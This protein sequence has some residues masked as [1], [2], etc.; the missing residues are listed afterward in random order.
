MDSVDR[1]KQVG[2]SRA[3]PLPG[4]IWVL[5][6]AAFIVALGYGIIAPVLPQF[7]QS[8][9]LGVAA[10]S[11]VVSAF[12][13]FRLMFAPAGGKL[14]DRFGEQPVYVTGLLIVAA[15]TFAVAF[16]QNY[17]QLL[18]FRGL[19]GL[20]STMFSV[21]AMALIVRSAPSHARAR[22]TG[23]YA[24]AFLLG[25]IAG[26]VLGGLMA[27][28]GMSVPFLIYG[29][30]L[31]A[32]AVI[33]QVALSRRTRRKNR[34]AAQAPVLDAQ[35]TAAEQ[36]A[37]GELVIAGLDSRTVASEQEAPTTRTGGS[38][39]STAPMRFREAFAE[40]GYR[41]AL[42]GGLANGWASMGIRVAIYPLFVLH[43]LGVGPAAAGW[44][45][46]IFAIGN[47]AAVTF[48]GRFADRLGRKPFTVTGF[49]VL[50]L[51]TIALGRWQDLGAFLVLSL[52][53]GVGA[54]LLNPAQQAVVADVVGSDRPS[55]K[56]LSRFQMAMD[57]GGIAGPIVAGWIVDHFS[58]GPAFTVSGILALLASLFWLTARE[59]LPSSRV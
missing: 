44:A 23:H 40:S 59:T 38:S 26:P 37:A 56:V 17:W 55:G 29:C 24:S 18:I 5:I 2:K 22:A 20:G 25:S 27:G 54:G 41:A 13:F 32:A 15:S 35:Q 46:T 12:A 11:V 7:A 33:V 6:G 31:V 1:P 48:T 8:F 3:A 45:L 19:G 53:A 34:E 57:A 50:G 16:A 42:F 43:V 10:A 47:V 14:I 58:Y 49:A 28:L 21:S 30:G 36:A 52:V 4:D 39:A 9:G 51:A